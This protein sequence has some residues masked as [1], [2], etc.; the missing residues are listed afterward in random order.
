MKT[1]ELTARLASIDNELLPLA[2][3]RGKSAEE[4]R[5]MSK[6]AA[7][8]DLTKAEIDGRESQ[9]R[10]E[11]PAYRKELEAKYGHPITIASKAA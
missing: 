7:E 11:D 8:Y 9:A 10:F 2:A 1:L 4:F 3:K 6:L 5:R